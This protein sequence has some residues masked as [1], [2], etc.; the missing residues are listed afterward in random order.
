[1]ALYVLGNFEWHCRKV[2]FPPAPLPYN[3][4]ELCP[5]FNLAVAE[6]YAQDY[7]VPELPQVVFMAMLLNDVV[8]LGV[9]SR[10]GLGV[11]GV[12]SWRPVDRKR[13]V[14]RMRRRV[15]GRTAKPPSS[16]GDEEETEEM[17]DYER[18]NFR[19][20][21]RSASCTPRPLPEDYR[22]LCLHFVLSK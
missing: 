13:P 2:V 6:E 14:T 3:Y 7:E 15:R 8:K 12:G 16:D 17:A 4:R 19:W 1:M 10:H 22:E 20:H 18:E 5:D 21:W 11:T 9:L